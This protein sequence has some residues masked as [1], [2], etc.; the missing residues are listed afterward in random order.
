M[1]EEGHAGRQ[2]RRVVVA[3]HRLFVVVDVVVSCIVV[4]ACHRLVDV[5]VFV[6]DVVACIL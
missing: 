5:V 2:L 3:S 1:D 6:D 4:V